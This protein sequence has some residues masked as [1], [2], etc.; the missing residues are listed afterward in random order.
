MIFVFVSAVLRTLQIFSH[1]VHSL[2]DL[3]S[4]KCITCSLLI[5]VA[6]EYD[7]FLFFGSTWYSFHWTLM[8]DGELHAS[9]SD[10]SGSSSIK[11]PPRP[12]LARRVN[13]YLLDGGDN[14]KASTGSA[15]RLFRIN[16][17]EDSISK[18]C[19]NL[20]TTSE[21][22]PLLEDSESLTNIMSSCNSLSK[23]RINRWLNESGVNFK[24]VLLQ[25]SIVI[26]E[27]RTATRGSKY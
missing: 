24:F 16:L 1:C 11:L 10:G 17:P 20:S 2:D 18:L 14:E 23:F 12:Q 4:D 3:P 21:S 15:T 25:T 27:K 9:N 22:S 8:P 19:L 5:Q 26:Q 6:V 7:Q 13:Y